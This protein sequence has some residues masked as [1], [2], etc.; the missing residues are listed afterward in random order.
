MIKV[1]PDVDLDHFFQA[2]VVAH[3]LKVFSWNYKRG[4]L[5]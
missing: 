5:G 3:L 2:C 1:I 4:F